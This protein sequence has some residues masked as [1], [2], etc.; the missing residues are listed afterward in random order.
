MIVV[1]ATVLVD[2]LNGQDAA[3]EAAKRLARK[4][5]EWISPGIWRYELGNALWKS[6][7]FSGA[8]R[9]QL[10][11]DL[12]SAGRLLVET[13]DEIDAAAVFE[14]AADTELSFYDASYVWLARARRT[15][16]RTR[17]K[18]VLA[19]CSDVALPMPT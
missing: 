3:M 4:D 15:E 7:R 2:F 10:R 19:K 12:A 9:D 1:D 5:P 18:A 16:L 8:D 6:F 14:I 17:D 11:R 13:V